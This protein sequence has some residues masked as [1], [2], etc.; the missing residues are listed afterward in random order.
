MSKVVEAVVIVAAVYFT[1]GLAAG[2]VGLGSVGT[3]GGV[4]FSGAIAASAGLMA[5]S[6]IIGSALQQ[7]ALRNARDAYNAGLQARTVTGISTDAPLRYIYGTARVGSN[8]VAMFTS[9]TNDIYRHLVCVHAAHECTAIT[10]VFINS[11]SLGVLDAQGNATSGKF[12]AGS[13]T[14]AVTELHIGPVFTLAQTPIYTAANKSV[15]VYT[16]PIDGSAAQP[17]TI[18]N[19]VNAL[20]TTNMPPNTNCTVTYQVASGGTSRVRVQ[21]HL[22]SISDPAD[23]TLL[24]ELTSGLW[25]STSLLSEYCYTVVRLDLREPEFQ[26]GMPAI[27]VVIQGKKVYDFR[28]G[29]YGLSSNPVLAMYDYL[30][31]PLCGV[32]PTDIPLAYYIAAANV[33]DDTTFTTI[34]APRYTFNGAITSDNSQVKTLEAMAGSMGGTIV[35][36]TWAV[37]AGNYVAPVMALSQSDIVG[38]ITITPGISGGSI[39]NGVKGQFIDINNNYSV[40]D[41]TPFQNTAYATA[42]GQDYFVNVDYPFTSTIQAVNNLASIY[43]QDQRNSYTIVG[44]FSLKVWGLQIGDRVTFT[45]TLFGQTN[46]IYRITNKEYSPVSSVKL[47]MK[48]DDPSIWAKASDII[49]PLS[50]SSNLPNPWIIDAVTSLSCTSGDATILTQNDGTLVPRI[51]VTW[52]QVITQT[53]LTNGQI[54]LQWQPVVHGATAV[55]PFVDN[56]PW[57]STTVSGSDTQAYADNVTPGLYYNIR[58]RSINPYFNVKSDWVYTAFQ[59]VGKTILP[60][61]VTNF[62]VFIRADGTRQFSFDTVNQ[63]VSP[64]LTFNG[65]YRIKYCLYSV[66]PVWAN[67]TLLTS[68]SIVTSPFETRTPVNGIYTFGIVAVDSSGNESGTVTLNANVNIGVGDYIDATNSAGGLNSTMIQT[69]NALNAMIAQNKAETAQAAADTAAA[70]IAGISSDNVL[71]RGEKG[72]VILDYNTLIANQIGVRGIDAQAITFGVDSSAYDASLIAL[73]TYL[74]S[75]SPAYTNLSADTS[76]DGPTFRIYF[77]NAY[78]AEQLLLN[79]IAAKAKSL[80]DG[81]QATG[82]SALVTAN[83]AQVSATAANTQLTAIASDG[84]LSPG[85]KSVVVQDYQVILNEQS[86]IDLQANYFNVTTSKTNYDV[87]ITNLTNYLNSL[88]GWNVIPGNNII[89]NGSQ[90]RAFFATVYTT[91]QAVLND[92]STQAGILGKSWSSLLAVTG[93]ISTLPI[94][95]VI[96]SQSIGTSQIATAAVQSA[97]IANNAIAN[98]HITANAVTTTNIS[99]N[100]VTVPAA[101]SGGYYGSTEYYF[102]HGAGTQQITEATFTIYYP[103]ATQVQLLVTYNTLHNGNGGNSV[104]EVRLDG[105]PIL[106]STDGVIQIDAGQSHVASRVVPIAAGSHT[107]T[108]FFSNTWSNGAWWLQDWSISAIGLMR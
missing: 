95:T 28:T 53:V 44:D 51:L 18:L 21:R 30:T 73:T 84:V 31:S 92:I 13:T 32:S 11:E 4:A 68:S 12:A 94:T 102:S 70:Q 108:L 42:D 60:A 25:T 104:V 71:S 39:Y 78:N 24:A 97:Q 106:T 55:L 43:L 59:A 14:T 47:T 1:A 6:M 77:G 96:A 23:P 86:G 56:Y 9:G 36:T 100:S 57:F 34:A 83:A 99:P 37:H 16:A 72:A 7:H 54:E 75:L 87:A 89:I 33:C 45:S 66:P 46:K 58:V 35:A 63:I 88:T 98:Q 29:T 91:K 67:M 10:Q 38:A 64:A 20:V 81:A 105:S 41:Y 76:I 8:V 101:V 65:G 3:L 85:E 5:G 19:V 90:F 93:A 69:I 17:V 62:S 52:P 107:Y 103:Q 80:A 40:T 49:Q 27:E 74:N 79:D 82:T 50:P 61:Q 26:N 22:G 2:A 48:Q 15:R